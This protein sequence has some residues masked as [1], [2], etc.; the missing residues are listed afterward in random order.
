MDCF[1]W[2][3]VPFGGLSVL[4]EFFG[5]IGFVQLTD[6]IGVRTTLMRTAKV[7]NRRPRTRA[8]TLRNRSRASFV[9][10]P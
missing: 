3:R 1:L 8:A 7:E 4:I 6:Y 10:G 5:R 9:S 2:V